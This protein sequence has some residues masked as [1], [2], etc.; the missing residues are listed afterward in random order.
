MFILLAQYLIFNILYSSCKIGLSKFFLGFR[1]NLAWLL[2]APFVVLFGPGVLLWGPF[3]AFCLGLGAE[4]CQQQLNDVN[5]LAGIEP[6]RAAGG[7]KF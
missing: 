5:Q 1:F 4:G 7:F 2:G 3:W 6:G